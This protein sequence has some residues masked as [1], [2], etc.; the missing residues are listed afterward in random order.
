MLQPSLNC[1]QRVSQGAVGCKFAHLPRTK[2]P[3]MTA[4]VQHDHVWRRSELQA[5]RD[6]LIRAFGQIHRY[7]Q[8][9]LSCSV[10]EFGG[11]PLDGE[12]RNMER[13]FAGDYPAGFLSKPFSVDEIGEKLNGLLPLS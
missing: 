5:A 9:M 3:G 10:S 12:D 2:E 13:P 4:V 6:R 1:C 8:K 11:T 7:T